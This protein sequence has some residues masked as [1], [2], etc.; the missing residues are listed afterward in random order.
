MAEVST[1]YGV[2]YHTVDIPADIDSVTLD[3]SGAGGGAGGANEQNEGGYGASM[4]ITVDVATYGRRL[5]LRVGEKGR[6]G[7]PALGGSA[8]RGGYDGGD[9]SPP[10]VE[11]PAWGAGGGGG[12]SVVALESD[13]RLSSILG[14]AGAGGGGASSGDGTVA[15]LAGG[16][17]GGG[18]YNPGG[19][20]GGFLASTRAGGSPG[21]AHT[22]GL[23]NGKGGKGG[24][25]V[26]EGSP[27]TDIRTGTGGDGG[28]S[29]TLTGTAEDGDGW[30]EQS[31]TEFDYDTVAGKAGTSTLPGAGGN[32]S[33]GADIGAG[34]GGG[35]TSWYDSGRT[36]LVS[37]SR[38]TNINDG[39]ITIRWESNDPPSA[40]TLVPR[41]NF[42]ANDAAEFLWTHND[43]N[44]DDLQTA[45]RLEIDNATT[46]ASA[47]NSGKQP[48]GTSA[49]T[50]VGGT[51]ANG[52]TYRWRVKTWD[53]DDFEGEWSD[54]KTFDTAAKP[55]SFFTN[56]ANNGDV[57]STASFHPA[58]NYT[59][60]AGLNQTHHRLRLL[61]ST[62]TTVIEDTGK[63]SAG[64]TSG[65]TWSPYQFSTS[66]EN[67]TGYIVEVTSWN[68]KGVAS[69]PSQRSFT[70]DYVEPE[71]P[72][73]TLSAKDDLGYVEVDIDNGTPSGTGVPEVSFNEVYRRVSGTSEWTFTAANVGPG[74]IHRDYNASSGYT[75]EY[76]VRA[77]ATTGAKADSSTDTVV[78]N[79]QGVWLHLLAA[80]GASI[81]QFRFSE[82]HEETFDAMMG[83][84]HYVGRTYPSS[85]VS[86]QRRQ[87]F[88]AK[89]QATAA[90]VKAIRA[91]LEAREAMVM[92]DGRGGRS[93]GALTMLDVDE[94][95]WGAHVTVEVEQTEDTEVV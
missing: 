84:N 75:W 38:G 19:G 40:P 5:Y 32:A 52:V 51:L 90:E 6:S 25:I 33:T 43:P 7:N 41:A 85:E 42:D 73:F 50:L 83:D 68:S 71:T 24:G 37:F 74:G 87:A 80:P 29:S 63:T 64:T 81:K 17:G 60:P 61:D 27:I 9:G 54:Y 10:W 22:G 30:R 79:L 89:I 86:T 11:Y 8:S 82:D 62:G 39:H 16:G 95:P 23:P 20:G 69:T 56:P 57:I 93:I 58:Y 70:V 47:F 3:I 88:S 45:Y 13:Y 49:R 28:N 59:D 67:L 66:L 77:V 2:G 44:P 26:T 4:R 53:E 21:T 31:N 46:G 12:S 65:T 92:R 14:W 1:R 72:T 15:G 48:S 36:T 55:T 94:T 91:L 76:M 18:G 34:G 35:G 78:L